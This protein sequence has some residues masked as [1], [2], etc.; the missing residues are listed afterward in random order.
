MAA[1]ERGAE[2]YLPLHSSPSKLSGTSGVKKLPRRP[3]YGISDVKP[4]ISLGTQDNNGVIATSHSGHRL[5]FLYFTR[6]GMMLSS[7]AAASC[8]LRG[9]EVSLEPF[10]VAVALEWRAC[11]GDV[12][13]NAVVADDDGA[14]GEI[15][16]RLFQCA[17]RIDV[18]IVGRFVEQQQ[19]GAGRSILA[20]WHAV[21]LAARQRAD[22][23]LLVRRP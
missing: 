4:L 1:N 11:G 21:A 20:R 13:R 5:N 16:Q 10:H 7:L 23:L 14:A 8:R 12:S 15:L 17:Q 2:I 6:C 18:E 22:F 19:I 3:A 9:P